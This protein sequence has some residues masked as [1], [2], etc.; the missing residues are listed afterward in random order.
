MAAW[1]STRLKYHRPYREQRIELSFI[2]KCFLFQSFWSQPLPT[3]QPSVLRVGISFYRINNFGPALGAY[4]VN[5]LQAHPI[6][7][8]MGVGI[9]KAGVNSCATPAS[10]TSRALYFCSSVSALPTASIFPPLTTN[11]LA[12]V[13]CTVN[14]INNRVFYK[15]IG[16][17]FLLFA[18]RC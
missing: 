17:I 8:K 18:G 15:H 11:A 5:L 7:I 4:Q 10:S 3:I 1:P 12:V 14:G 13:K 6:F 16:I 9:N 2:R